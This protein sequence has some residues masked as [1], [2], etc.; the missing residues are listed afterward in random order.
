[1]P[2][3]PDSGGQVFMTVQT[4]QTVS[5]DTWPPPALMTATA[6]MSVQTPANGWDLYAAA[7]QASNPDQLY[8]PMNVAP[9]DAVVY[10]TVNFGTVLD[11]WGTQRAAVLTGTGTNPNISHLLQNPSAPW[12]RSGAFTMECWVQTRYYACIPFEF[13]PDTAGTPVNTPGYGPSFIV[14]SPQNNWMLQGNGPSGLAGSGISTY[15]YSVSDGLWH[16]IAYSWDGNQTWTLYIDGRVTAQT[17]ASV[18]TNFLGC[19]HVGRGSSGG[20]T[21]P[22]AGNLCFMAAYS[23]ALPVSEIRGHFQAAPAIRGTEYRYAVINSSPDNFWA[24]DYAPPDG[25]VYGNV[26]F[27]VPDPWGSKV[28]AHFDGTGGQII[29]NFPQYGS[30]QHSIECWFRMTNPS[31]GYGSFADFN[32]SSTTTPDASS[33]TNPGPRITILAQ[34]VTPQALLIGYTIGGTNIDAR[35]LGIFLDGSWHHVAFTY[36]GVQTLSLYVDGV[37]AMARLTTARNPSTGRWRVGRG[38]SPST[39]SFL[40][41]DISCVSTYSRAMSAAEILAHY[42]AGRP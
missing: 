39:T 29:Q 34:G 30:G 26:T 24:L 20:A 25:T 14:S 11:P 7:V 33:A 21:S 17:T 1:M 15:P 31:G 37:L 36:D 2:V 3:T 41:G 23:R 35:Q 8:W 27:G 12:T 40:N 18:P 16:H 13:N 19:W 28:A 32:T 5:P 42:K 9:A 38:A 22:F 10:G 6:G 4:T